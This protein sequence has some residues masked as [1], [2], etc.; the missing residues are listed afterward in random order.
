[1]KHQF[2]DLHWLARRDKDLPLPN[3]HF[4]N[5][6]RP[7]TEM[8]Y[9]SAPNMR[10]DPAWRR[11]CSPEWLEL[12]DAGF[13][14]TLDGTILSRASGLIAVNIGQCRDQDIEAAVAHEWRH[15]WQAY[16]VGPHKPA[17]FDLQIGHQDAIVKYFSRHWHEADALRFERSLVPNDECSLQRASWLGWPTRRRAY[18]YEVPIYRD[19]F[20]RGLEFL[21]NRVAP[22]PGFLR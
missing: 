12:F 5:D 22:L 7:G 9:Y 11:G 8:A 4:Y 20:D 21:W 2:F 1:M 16:N 13:T 19:F 18:G 14:W 6:P 17:V 3:L 10:V 15:H